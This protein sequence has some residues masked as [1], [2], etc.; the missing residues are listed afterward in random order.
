MKFKYRLLIVFICAL[1]IEITAVYGFIFLEQRN[2][3]G[4]FFMVFLNPY[5][6]LPMNHFNVECKTF[7]DRFYL[8]TA[9]AFGFGLGVVFVRPFILE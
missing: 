7:T 5:I 6:C 4:M 2:Y 8:A 3:I 9:F 1:F